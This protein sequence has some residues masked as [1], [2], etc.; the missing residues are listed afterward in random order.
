MGLF[1]ALLSRS[2]V[3]K[4]LENVALEYIDTA[5]ETAE[6]NTL[7]IKALDPNGKMRRD[8]ALF[9]SRA[10]AFYLGSTVILIFFYA[11]FSF[12]V[13]GEA[14]AASLA[15]ITMQKEVIAEA[16]HAMANL[17]LP[18][19]GSWTAIVSASFGVNYAN[20]KQGN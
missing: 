15:V 12:F 17:F 4:S 5:G 9:A 8:L 14:N 11:G 1:S 20:V 19:T 2:G 13:A 3:T 6:A 7:M 16:V 10:Y 18:I